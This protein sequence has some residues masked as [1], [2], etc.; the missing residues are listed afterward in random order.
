MA[1]LTG[2]SPCPSK[3]FRVDQPIG[4]GAA[5]TD[6]TADCSTTRPGG[7]HDDDDCVW[8]PSCEDASVL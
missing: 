2:D 6:Y 3:Q 8:R 4:A 1:A 5:T 7:A